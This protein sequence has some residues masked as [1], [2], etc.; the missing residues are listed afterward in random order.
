M[1]T[2]AC[3]GSHE[4]THARAK[5][6]PS[7][8]DSSG[9]RCAG[10]A[11]SGRVTT[12]REQWTVAEFEPFDVRQPEG[13]F[14]PFD[15]T[16]EP[17]QEPEAAI[18]MLGGFATSRDELIA[19]MR[20][21]DEVERRLM[22]EPVEVAFATAEAGS[23]GFGHIVGVGIGEEQV[24]GIV[25]GRPAVVASATSSSNAATLTLTGRRAAGREL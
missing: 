16:Q 13:A 5:S 10:V 1:E 12:C 2:I 19:L 25:I 20:A 21:R 24:G 8:V 9:A 18:E 23:A 17:E 6:S 7:G 11:Q 4:R 14:E 15:V 22:V 3:G